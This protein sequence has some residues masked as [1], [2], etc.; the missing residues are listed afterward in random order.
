[1][2]PAFSHSSASGTTP[3]SGLN[4]LSFE[5]NDRILNLP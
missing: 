3:G 5:R 4:T 1:V 2:M